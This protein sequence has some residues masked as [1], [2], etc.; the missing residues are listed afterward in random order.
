[1]LDLH[2]EGLVLAEIDLGLIAFAKA[3]VDP[4]GHDARPDVTRLLFNNKPARHVEYFSVPARRGRWRR[5][6]R[7]PVRRGR[8]RAQRHAARQ[9]SSRT[10]SMAI[11]PR[12]QMKWNQGDPYAP[13]GQHHDE[14]GRRSLGV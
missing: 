6:I 12:H 14:I 13:P 10:L 3:S 2:E 1:M 4:V 5:S 7:P 11:P 9:R 8:R